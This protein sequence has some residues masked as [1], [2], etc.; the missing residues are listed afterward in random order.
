MANAV[1]NSINTKISED[2]IIILLNG[3]EKYTQVHIRLLRFLQN[4]SEYGSMDDYYM[5][6]ATMSIYEKYYPE[7]DQQVIKIAVA[8]LYKDCMITS[9]SLNTM[10]TVRGAFSSQTTDLGNDFIKFFGI[11]KI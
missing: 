6:A 5:A 8:D 1:K 7:E 10:Q 3:I 2:R 4:P 9:N 11:E